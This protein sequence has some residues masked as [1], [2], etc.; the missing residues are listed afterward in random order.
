MS[1]LLGNTSTDL[2]LVQ[3]FPRAR[4]RV[5]RCH[6]RQNVANDG[7]WAEFAREKDRT[8]PARCVSK[9]CFLH[10]VLTCQVDPSRGSHDLDDVDP[11]PQNGLSRRIKAKAKT[12]AT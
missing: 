5:S 4:P 11:R 10:D 1:G 2:E 7:A 6:Q 12:F 3:S 8:S 9:E